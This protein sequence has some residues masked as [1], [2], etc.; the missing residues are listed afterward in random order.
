MPYQSL[1][2]ELNG[3]CDF[4]F[5][6]Q[7]YFEYELDGAKL[8]EQCENFRIIIHLHYFRLL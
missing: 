2:D 7:N 4:T 3:A 1:V 8:F 5:N 6:G